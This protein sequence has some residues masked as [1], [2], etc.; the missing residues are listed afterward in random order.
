[1]TVLRGNSTGLSTSNSERR[2]TGSTHRC[3]VAIVSTPRDTDRPRQSWCRTPDGLQIAVYD[4]GG[5]G[6]DL[7]LV[8]ATGFC[9]EVFTPLARELESRFHCWGL[10]L[11]AHGRSDRPPDGNFAWS[12]FATDVLAVVD[13][14]G[15]SSPGGFGHSAGGASLLLAEQARPGRFRSLYCFEPVVLPIEAGD[16]PP[17]FEDNPLTLGARRRRDSFPTAE[18][19][20]V[21]FSSKPPFSELDPEVLCCYVEAGFEPIPTAEGG[22]GDAIRLRCRRE[23]EAMIYA[24]GPRHGAFGRLREIECPV[25]LAC[26]ERTD[27]FG[28]RFLEAD[29]ARLPRATIEVL[30]NVGHFGPLQRPAVVSASVV[31]ALNPVSDTPSP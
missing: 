2:R 27:A 19:A 9:A 1:M 29:A 7:L 5:E 17:S 4:F 30:P 8:H 14:L 23:D 16:E 3:T 31:R 11:R 22:D 28:P 20:F 6:P 21:N 13:H 15:L 26:G 12:G 10:D 18:D 25:A 24:Y